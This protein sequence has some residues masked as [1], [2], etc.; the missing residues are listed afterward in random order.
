[1]PSRLVARLADAR[2]ETEVADQVARAR[3][4]VDLADRGDQRERDRT[5]DAG[6]REQTLD[7][8]A[9]ESD[10]GEFALDKREL[11]A[12]DVEA[13]Q[14]GTDGDLLVGRQR[15][16]GEPGPAL[17][18]EE[19]G[20]GAAGE[21]VAVQNRLHLVLQARALAHDRAPPRDKPPQGLQL[22]VGAPNAGQVAGGEQLGE[23]AGV[24]LVRL[25]LRLRDRPRP[26]R[27]RDHDPRHVLLEQARD[28]EGV[29][30]RLERD[31]V[32]RRQALREQAQRLGR[33]RDP[34]T[35]ADGAALK[36][37]H[38][39]ELPMDIETDRPHRP[40]TAFPA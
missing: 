4:A 12:G 1:V 40:V 21:Q 27:V 6:D 31:L 33:R 16:L 3:E 20:G 11:L 36:D 19:V 26:H 14:R 18:A 25:H 8:L 38:L 37:R 2:V 28:R 30:G 32:C 13:A 35:C 24:D 39:T 17:L 34:P 29:H 15:L 10:L 22:L 7:L 9:C 23:H 5:V